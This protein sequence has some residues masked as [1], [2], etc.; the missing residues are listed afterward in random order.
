MRKENLF[1]K[2]FYRGA[3]VK[4]EFVLEKDV[5]KNYQTIVEDIED[6]YL[7]LLT[8]LVDKKAVYIEEGQELT[9]RFESD[10]KKQ[11][12]ITSV[13]VI[14]NRPGKVPLLVCCKPEEISRT[15]MRRYARFSV[16][17]KCDLVVDEVEIKGRVTDI[18]MSG[19]C[20]E[21]A[22]GQG[23][24]ENDNLRIVISTPDFDRLEFTGEMIRFYSATANERVGL[25]I[26][27]REIKT[28]ML[29]VLKNYL[30][31]LQLLRT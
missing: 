30:F 7:V 28:G 26:D 12:Y 10:E 22:R 27:I 29:E 4:M 9:L 11:A 24:K 15:S 25:A 5:L 18:S 16:D 21:I 3:A 31:Q 6:Q 8:P 23:V 17:L 1:M 13:F 14:E 2:L 19:C 20:V